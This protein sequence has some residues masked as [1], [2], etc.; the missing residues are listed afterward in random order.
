M[1]CWRDV[2]GRVR[3]GGDQQG[4]LREALQVDGGARQQ[5][6]RSH[7]ASGRLLHRNPRHRRFRNLLGKNPEW[8]QHSPARHNFPRE[9]PTR[10]L[11]SS[12]VAVV[13]LYCYWLSPICRT[14]GFHFHCCSNIS[15]CFTLKPSSDIRLLKP[16]KC[17]TICVGACWVF[18]VEHRVSRLSV[19]FS[20][21][22][23]FS[24]FFRF[25]TSALV[26]GNFCFSLKCLL[27]T[28]AEFLDVLCTLVF[29]DYCHYSVVHHVFVWFLSSSYFRHC[30]M[31]SDKSLLFSCFA[32]FLISSKISTHNQQRRQHRCH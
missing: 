26:L 17:L 29:H 12:P 2:A 18:A 6:A 31:L 15:S 1:V 27:Y 20:S 30:L 28:L 32:V 5:V 24:P 8:P 7:Q 4:D 16:R 14:V 21:K 9:H 3:G 10:P 23:L 22:Y 13:Q 19:M 11:T 25:S